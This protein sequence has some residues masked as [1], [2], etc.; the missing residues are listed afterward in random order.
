MM[1][2]LAMGGYGQYVWG[3]YGVAFAAIAAEV[4]LLRAR[5]RR[6]LARA[7]AEA[8]SADGT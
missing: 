5:A 6:A 3:S 4:I 2:W 1:E 8:E 7:R